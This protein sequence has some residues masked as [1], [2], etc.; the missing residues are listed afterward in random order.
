MF[1]Y[2]PAHLLRQPKV[3]RESRR[4]RAVHAPLRFISTLAND[5]FLLGFGHVHG[6]PCIGSLADLPQVGGDSLHGATP[7]AVPCGPYLAF[8][9]PLVGCQSLS[10]LGQA[11]HWSQEIL[12][13]GQSPDA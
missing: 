6:P 7:L 5:D 11:L 8:L 12:Q 2:P 9:Y 1:Y 3:V 10:R 13:L 4:V